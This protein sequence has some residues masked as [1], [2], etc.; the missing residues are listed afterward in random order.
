MRQINEIVKELF[1]FVGITG[2]IKNDIL[3]VR[4]AGKLILEIEELKS[5]IAELEKK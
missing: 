2:G 5:R 4:I 3:F 1:E